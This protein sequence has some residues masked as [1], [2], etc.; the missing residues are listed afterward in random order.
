MRISGRDRNKVYRVPASVD[1]MTQLRTVD[2]DV[3]EDVENE[4]LVHP[5]SISIFISADINLG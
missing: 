4:P 3:H 5:R 2:E 1:Q